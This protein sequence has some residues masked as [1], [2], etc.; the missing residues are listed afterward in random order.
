[1]LKYMKKYK[2]VIHDFTFKRGDLVLIRNSAIKDHLD[3]K[4]YERYLGP[5][6]V[7]SRSRGGSY[8]LAELDGM[9]MDRK[10]AQF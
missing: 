6:V 4:M 2:R 1:M 7:V 10:V 5:L 8:I 9:I 3:R